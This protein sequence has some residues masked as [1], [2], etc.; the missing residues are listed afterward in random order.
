MSLVPE[1]RK[2]RGPKIVLIKE[3]MKAIIILI[4]C[5]LKKHSSRRMVTV[6]SIIRRKVT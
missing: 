1:I 4:V 3:F 6:A 2:V 5:V